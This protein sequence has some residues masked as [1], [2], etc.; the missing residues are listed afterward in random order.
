MTEII[1]IVIAALLGVL[2]GLRVKKP[3]P[4]GPAGPMGPMGSTPPICPCQ[5]EK[6]E[7][8]RKQGLW[9]R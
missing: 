3:G 1:L 6:S 4:M 9:K 2:V 7:W 8:E 5:L